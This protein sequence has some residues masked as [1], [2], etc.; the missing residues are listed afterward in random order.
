M[1]KS[2]RHFIKYAYENQKYVNHIPKEFLSEI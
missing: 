2:H 1:P